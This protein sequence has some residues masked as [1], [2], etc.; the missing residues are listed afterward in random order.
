MGK[1]GVTITSS[2]ILLPEKSVTAIAAFADNIQKQQ[3]DC[4]FSSGQQRTGL[5]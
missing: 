1:I 4:L 5:P 3:R 2:F